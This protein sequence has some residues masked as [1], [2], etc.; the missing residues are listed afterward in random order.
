MMGIENTTFYY[1]NKNSLFTF[2]STLI[3][4]TELLLYS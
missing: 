2:I 3:E 4:K 1:N